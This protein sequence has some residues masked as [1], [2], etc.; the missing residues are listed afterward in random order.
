MKKLLSLVVAFTLF[1]GLT[2]T[3][4]EITKKADKN[5]PII[6]F[7]EKVMDYGTIA[8]GSDGQRIFKFKNTGKTPLIIT[9]AK[10]SCGCTVPV[11]PKE[12]I[13]NCRNESTL[14]H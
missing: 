12:P 11:W 7:E 3:A 6:E 5:A 4:Q 9:R 14:R 2:A 10:G 8:N 13:L 1:T